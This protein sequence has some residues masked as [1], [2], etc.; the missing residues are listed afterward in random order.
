M[1]FIR[2]LRRMT[3]LHHCVEDS[4]YRTAELFLLYLSK[5]P[6]DHHSRDIMEIMPSFIENKLPSLIEYF[7]SRIL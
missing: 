6:L 3:P 4:D 7:D 1:P 5:A 2:D